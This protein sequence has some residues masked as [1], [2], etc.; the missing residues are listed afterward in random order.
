MDPSEAARAINA[1]HVG[2]FAEALGLEIVSA[3]RDE[4]RARVTLAPGHRQPHGI[5]HG[6]VHA[7]V[8][9]SV[10]S[11]G[12]AIDAMGKGKTVVG[13]E[14]ATSFVRAV[15]EGTLDVVGVPVTRGSRTQLWDV[16]IRT[17]EGAVVATGRV[18]LLV[19]DPEATVG[20][21][22]IGGGA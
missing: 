20:G 2:T 15:R 19:L 13:L 12:A 1:V 17:A 5:V 22:A 14:N 6:G 9:E 8:I 21:A 11:I 3:S 7:A 18:R 4:V 16:T 10:A